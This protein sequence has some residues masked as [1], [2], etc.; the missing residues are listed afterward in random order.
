MHSSTPCPSHCVMCSAR[1]QPLLS[2]VPNRLLRN[3]VG[4]PRVDGSS[5]TTRQDV[6]FFQQPLGPVTFIHWQTSSLV[7]RAYPNE[8]RM[9]TLALGFL[10]RH[11]TF[12]SIMQPSCTPSS[13]ATGRGTASTRT[14]RNSDSEPERDS[15]AGRLISSSVPLWIYRRQPPGRL[16]LCA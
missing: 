13:S 1:R 16:W 14:V 8:H 10:N 2:S 4:H 7:R 11:R 5:P 12:E 3:P 6:S 15:R 9:D